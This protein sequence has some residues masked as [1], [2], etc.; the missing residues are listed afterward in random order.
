MRVPN[1]ASAALESDSG[2]DALLLSAREDSALDAMPNESDDVVVGLLMRR[3]ST[4]LR[5]LASR[6]LRIPSRF[7]ESDPAPPVTLTVPA[8][9]RRAGD[10]QLAADQGVCNSSVYICHR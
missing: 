4:T 1:S 9:R 2:G 5:R 6:F 3:R 8:A 7:S 10:D